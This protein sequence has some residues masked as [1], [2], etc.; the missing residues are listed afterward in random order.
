M[1]ESYQ[2]I[3]PSKWLR[4]DNTV[5]H[6]IL[7]NVILFLILGLLRF[8]S[9]FTNGGVDLFNPVLQE[10]QFAVQPEILWRKPWTFFSYMFTQIGVFHVLFNLIALYWFGNLFRSEL[11]NERVLPLYILGGLFG[12]IVYV[13][14]YAIFPN[15]PYLGGPMIGASGA[16][17]AFIAATAT[18]MPNLR[19]GLLLLGEIKLKWI[20]LGLVILDIILLPGSNTGGNLAHLGGALLGF[21]YIKLLQNGTDL[22]RPLQWFFRLFQKRS[23]SSSKLKSKKKSPLRVIHNSNHPHHNLLLDDILDKINASLSAA[24]KQWLTQYSKEK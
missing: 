10:L 15:S 22:T 7:A 14:L 13:S 8:P 24:E 21:C 16:V 17:M 4:K 3:S 5:H 19:I 23:T 20:A 12:A 11:G 9:L 1:N 6:L 18:L 2:A